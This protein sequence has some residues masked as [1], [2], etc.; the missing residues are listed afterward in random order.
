[1]LPAGEMW[2]VVMLSPKQ[3]QHARARSVD[4]AGCSM[5]MPVEVRRVL[6]VGRRSAS[7]A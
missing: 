1:M 5:V 2:S 4:A 7:Q 6:D 3:R